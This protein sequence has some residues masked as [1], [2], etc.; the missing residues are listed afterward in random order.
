MEKP[1]KDTFDPKNFL[2]KVGTG[3]NNNILASVPV[4]GTCQHNL[5]SRL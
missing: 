5:C 1:A 4:R 2:A 3:K